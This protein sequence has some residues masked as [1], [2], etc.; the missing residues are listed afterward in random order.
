MTTLD[1][2]HSDARENARIGPGITVAVTGA[3]GF[4]GGRLV[5]RLT[6]T[7]ADVTCLVRGYA[8]ARLHRAGAHIRRFDLGDMTALRGIG[9]VFHLA[10]D[11]AN[12]A[13]NFAA[14]RA[15]IE[16][17]L[18]NNCE[19]LVYVSS[20]VVYDIPDTG[21]VTEE[22]SPTPATSGYAHTKLALEADVLRAARE[23]GLSETI[24]QPTI[25]YGP[26]SRPWTIDPADMLRHGTVVL[27][28]DGCGLCNAVYVDDVVEAML[29][30]ATRPQAIG[31][32][33]LISG[34]SPV[35]WSQFY[36]AVARGIGA[37]GPQI[38]PVEKIT[39]LHGK[40]GKLRQLA[41]DP[42]FLFFG[43]LKIGPVRKLSRMP[44][45]LLPGGLRRSAERRW[46]VPTT[47][48]RGHVHVP[49]PGRM[50]FLQS[51]A[52]ISIAKAREELGYAPSFDLEAGMR[53][54]ASFLNEIHFAPDPP[55]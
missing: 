22:S 30:A 45:R 28:E 50:K 25:V 29:L 23:S 13:W 35:T 47:Q 5:E 19:R 36:E 20:F 12:T 11:W 43:A 27:P 46:M 24:I 41:R 53:P 8:G 31:Q 7:G 10:Y 32:R 9:I 37:P 40:F 21:D 54:T 15:L 3:T 42:E 2:T 55:G 18:A 33:Y 38:W 17:C 26:H 6:Q 1:S 51:R 49:N 52:T 4:I 34:P 44:L 48:R 14:L 16:G 39:A